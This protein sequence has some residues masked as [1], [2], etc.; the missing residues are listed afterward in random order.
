MLYKLKELECLEKICER[1]GSISVGG[2]NILNELKGILSC[3]T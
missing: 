1:V 2:E 3:N